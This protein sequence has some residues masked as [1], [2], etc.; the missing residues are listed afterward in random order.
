[1]PSQISYLD[2]YIYW[3]GTQETSKM[4]L[5][6]PEI[7]N[8]HLITTITKRKILDSCISLAVRNNDKMKTFTDH[9]P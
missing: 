4:G 5:S 7:V 9:Y 6:V 1:M 8:N 2:F 3:S